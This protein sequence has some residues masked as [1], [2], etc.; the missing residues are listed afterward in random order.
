M[1]KRRSKKQIV[2]RT[3]SVWDSWIIR[4]CQHSSFVLTSSVW[5]ILTEADANNVNILAKRIDL[6][7]VYWVLQSQ[8]EGTLGTLGV[9]HPYTTHAVKMDQNEKDESKWIK[10]TVNR[11]SNGSVT[12]RRES[13]ESTRPHLRRI[14]REKEL[15]SWRRSRHEKHGHGWHG[16]MAYTWPTHGLDHE[17]RRS[18]GTL[19]HMPIWLPPM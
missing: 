5:W 12:G 19:D 6:C 15:I 18:R 17:K 3:G 2:N 13:T 9:K 11:L 14:C 7:L 4:Y 8:R 16:N 1:F 10:Q